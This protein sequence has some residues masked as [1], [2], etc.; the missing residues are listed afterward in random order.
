[1]RP[2]ALG[3]LL[4]LI[5]PVLGHRGYVTLPWRV[6]DRP[7]AHRRTEG[8]HLVH[9]RLILV[10][11]RWRDPQHHC[12]TRRRK[13]TR[14]TKLTKQSRQSPKPRGRIKAHDPA[15]VLSV[16][17]Y[18]LGFHPSESLVM[19]L[20]RK[21]QIEL[22]ARIDLAAAAETDQLIAQ[23]TFI[24]RQHQAEGL[25]FIGY[26]E[27][28][29]QANAVLDV[30]VDGL[31]E[32][33]V[34]DA[35]Y[36]DGERWWS[37]MCARDGCCPADGNH[38]DIHSSRM[39]AE[40]VFAGLSA[41]PGRGDKADQLQAPAPAE[42]E[43]LRG[44]FDQTAKEIAP[45]SAFQREQLIGSIVDQYCAVP[46]ELADDLCV[47][48]AV[49]AADIKV[50]DVAWARMTRAEANLHQNL[51]SQVVRRTVPPFQSAPVCLLGLAAWIGGD[52]ALQVMCIERALEINPDYSLGWLLED[53]NLRAAPPSLWDQM[54]E[55][56]RQEVG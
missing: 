43:S 18:L 48:L 17:P 4:P 8:R 51:W 52:G 13:S 31:A 55:E 37:R 27:E 42:A 49:L 16:V 53:I 34:V 22:T 1:M 38:Y 33:G 23:L 50:R 9:S 2:Q 45:L 24:A 39:A 25:I 14:Q 20:L 30:V 19:V 47:Q 28:P 11:D 3:L 54:A 15:D 40:A 6:G 46:Q 41:V 44:L 29:D 56:M 12:M 35:L 21:R 36:A 26:S 32:F 5:L 7:V 10:H